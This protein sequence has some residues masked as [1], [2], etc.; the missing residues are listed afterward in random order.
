MY[1]K[2]KILGH[3]VHP[4]LVAYPIA[5]YT[6]TFVCY[7]VYN[8]NHVAFWFKVA[9]IANLAGIIMAAVAALPGFIDWLGIPSATKAK[10]TGLFHMLCNVIALILFAACFFL[11]KDKWN[12]VN[13]DIGSA[14]PL[15][16]I[17]FLIT[18]IAGFLGFSLIQKHHVGVDPFKEETIV[19][20]K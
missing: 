9:Y 8:S 1:S 13:P 20:R 6:A 17:G 18:L 16:A 7:I 5:F 15:T 4:M 2:I 11:Q 12:E 10:K 19:E 3:P 14:I